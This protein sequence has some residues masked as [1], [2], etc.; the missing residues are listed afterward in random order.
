MWTNAMAFA[1]MAV[2][3]LAL[4]QG[5]WG[6]LVAVA[7]LWQKRS[8]VFSSLLLSVTVGLVWFERPVHLVLDVLAVLLLSDVLDT[9]RVKRSPPPTNNYM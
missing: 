4:G 9:R 6:A 1:F 3:L 7:R 2:A 5:S 8:P